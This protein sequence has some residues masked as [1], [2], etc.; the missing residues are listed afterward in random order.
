MAEDE[1]VDRF[2]RVDD[3]DV[4]LPEHL[5]I[6]TGLDRRPARPVD[7]VDFLLIRV[8][9]QQVVGQANRFAGLGLRRL[10]AQQPAEI[11][12]V[13]EAGSGALLEEDPEGLPEGQIPV[14]IPLRLLLQ[15]LQEPLGD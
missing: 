3:L 12:A 9:P 4:P 5:D 14:G 8:H 2:H 10:E 15:E 13:F 1:V 7:I 6:G 11:V